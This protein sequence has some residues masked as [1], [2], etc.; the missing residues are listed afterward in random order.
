LSIDAMP[1]EMKEI[2]GKRV[3]DVEKLYLISTID[4]PI[5]QAMVARLVADFALSRKKVEE[6]ANSAK[7]MDLKEFGRY[8]DESG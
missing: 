1:R 7:S 5:K 8:C 2:L 4:D 3:N 6:L